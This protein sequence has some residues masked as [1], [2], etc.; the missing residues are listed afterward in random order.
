MLKRLYQLFLVVALLLVLPTISNAAAYTDGT[1]IGYA[2]GFGGKLTVQMI[3]SNGRITTVTIDAPNE[4]KG[5]G[6]IAAE[7]LPSRI[8]AANGLDHVD[9]ISGATI[10]SRAILEA[11]QSC[12][13]QACGGTVV[14]PSPTPSP[15]PTPSHTPPPAVQHPEYTAGTYIGYANG[16]GGKLTVQMIISNGWITAV[17]IDA[18]NETKGI[19]SIAAERLPSRI[20]AANGLDHVDTISGATITSRAILEAAQSCLDQ[21][22]GGTPVTPS[23]SPSPTPTPSPTPRPAVQHPE[24]HD[25]IYSAQAEGIFSKVTVALLIEN[26]YITSVFADAS[27]ETPGIGDTAARQL[28]AR[29]VAANTIEG[30][31]GVS[32]ATQTSDGILKA[33][34]L[35]LTKS[36]SSNHDTPFLYLPSDLNSIE[37]EAFSNVQ[38]SIVIVPDGCSA[39][40]QYAFSN[41][42]DLAYVIIPNSVTTIDATAFSG[43]SNLTILADQNST[44][45]RFASRNSIPVISK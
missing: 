20:I 5:I 17:T 30:V 1:Y 43:C 44:A 37:A 7:Q 26:G 22:C 8:I 11:A 28:S 23:P 9:T 3:I 41:C 29:I 21:A 13:D 33:A 38:A 27:Q 16:F 14:T 24:Y 15:T 2:S 42:T 34:Q 31:D 10:T 25:G 6:S 36:I 40:G 12:L 19:G 35:S 39:I 18:P 32:G 45:F 4:T